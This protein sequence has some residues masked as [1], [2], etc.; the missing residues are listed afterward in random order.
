MNLKQKN[1]KGITLIALV[2]TIVVLLILAGV[3]IATLTGESDIIEE[4]LEAKET[5]KESTKEEKSEA[6]LMDDTMYELMYRKP[7]KVRDEKPGVL[8]GDSDETEEIGT[9]S[10]PYQISSIEDLV[11]FSNQVNGGNSFSGKYV[12]LMKSLDFDSDNS[13]ADPTTKEFGDVNLDGK[14]EGLK[15]ELSKGQGFVPI[16]NYNSDP[17]PFAGTFL[18]N[19]KYIKN[20]YINVIIEELAE[21]DAGLFGYNTGTIQDVYVLNCDIY[22]ETTFAIVGGI[23]GV[24]DGIVSRCGTSG[25]IE[26]KASGGELVN[27]NV[28]KIGGIAGQISIEGENAR[29]NDCYNLS[30]MYSTIIM[31]DSVDENFASNGTVGGIVGSASR[32]DNIISNCYN[33]GNIYS[34]TNSMTAIGGILGEIGVGSGIIFSGGNFNPN[35]DGGGTVEKCYSVGKTSV[36]Y[37]GEPE[38]EKNR[39]FCGSV[40]GDSRGNAIVNYIYGIGETPIIGYIGEDEDYPNTITNAQIKTSTELKSSNILSLLGNGFKKDSGKKN[41]GYPLLAWQ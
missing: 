2:I 9:E 27:M 17:V 8:E 4:A 11:A 15:V 32:K 14:T 5:T 19:E 41:G 31:P 6:Q 36:T 37:N 13:Y 38:L 34:E 10:N 21:F 12:K 22:V 40:I 23:V 26:G 16:G 30:D 28:T 7:A 1:N 25:I 29:I 24:Q 35:E 18:G 33:K 3:S 20:L 39:V